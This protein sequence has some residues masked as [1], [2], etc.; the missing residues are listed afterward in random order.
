MKLTIGLD[1]GTQSARGVLVN[2][3]TGEVL[4]SAVAEYAHPLPDDCLVD[5]ADY[6]LALEQ[7]LAQLAAGRD[8]AGIAVDATALT[9]VP[10]A[11]DGRLLS[12]HM[13]D[14]P[15]ARVKLW[16][17][18][19]AQPYADR[20]L[21]LAAAHGEPFLKNTGGAV[22]SEWTIPKLMETRAEAPDVWAGTDLA[23]DLGDYIT[24]RLT[25]NI[26]RS[27]ASMCYKSCW[28]P[29][30]G[31]PGDGFL[32]SLAPGF[33]SDYRRLMRGEIRFPGERAGFLTDEWREKLGISCHTAVA[34][35]QPDGNTPPVAMGAVLDGDVSM[36]IGTS[37]VM[38]INTGK[39]VS[40]DGLIGAA[41]GGIA[42]GLTALECGQN[43]TGELLGWYVDN[44]LPAAY[45]RE[46]EAKGVSPHALLSGLARR[47]WENRL[48][49]CN[50]WSGSRCAP[51]DLS[52]AGAISGLT[53]DTRP[54]DVYL[55][56]VQSLA[57][58]AREMLDMCRKNGAEI[59]RIF[60][61]G[62]VARKSPLLMQ[63]L[64]DI[65]GLPISVTASDE[66]SAFGSAVLAAA[67]AGIHPDIPSAC[68]AMCSGGFASYRPDP[69]HRADYE[70]LYARSARIRTMMARIQHECGN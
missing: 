55:A 66:A 60:A 7:L 6:D 22:S 26:T 47:P 13:P 29:E 21:E 59:K 27:A 34:A 58:S 41:P 20:A 54:E 24:W 45:A 40:M 2:A 37:M 1:F 62:G 17:R 65:T 10:V 35:G 12:A 5:G 33:A 19:T 56:L 53:L 61:A 67:A 28:T 32:D 50:W 57:V 64:A 25:G 30:R 49:A 70:K 63:Q 23:L 69:A 36:T 18:H 8:I 31:L 16:K 39:S 68:A 44:M 4:C 48:V 51:A 9:L 15:H 3:Q 11:R 46:A 14:A 38:L 43:C 52:L 42:P